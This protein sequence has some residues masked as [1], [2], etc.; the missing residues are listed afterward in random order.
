MAH[1]FGSE[2]GLH[3]RFAFVDGQC[4]WLRA[5]GCLPPFKAPQQR[6]GR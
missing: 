4:H 3:L 5:S 1:A 2:A 6:S